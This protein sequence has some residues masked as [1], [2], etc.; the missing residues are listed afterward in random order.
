MHT[1]CNLMKQKHMQNHKDR[2]T[3]GAV[4]TRYAPL[5]GRTSRHGK[6]SSLT[7]DCVWG[8]GGHE[9]VMKNTTPLLCI[10]KGIHTDTCTLVYPPTPMIVSV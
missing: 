7:S 2:G 9:G 8:E 4:A 3:R 1:S 5:V 6:H 10:Q